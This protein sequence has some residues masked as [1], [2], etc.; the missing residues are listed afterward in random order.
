MLDWL[1]HRESYFYDGS[2]HATLLLGYISIMYGQAGLDSFH[3]LFLLV[4]YFTY[5][6]LH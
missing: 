5:P 3:I 1:C 2:I 4:T 6:F